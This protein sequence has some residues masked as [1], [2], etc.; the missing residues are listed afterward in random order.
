VTCPTNYG[1]SIGD[2]EVDICAPLT[3]EQRSPNTSTL[4]LVYE[5][6]DAEILCVQIDN[7]TCSLQCP[8]NY[9]PVPSVN[10]GTCAIAA[11]DNRVPVNGSCWMSGD[12]GS[13][14]S[15]CY[16]VVEVNRCYSTCPQLTSPNTTVAN[17]W[18][19]DVVPCESRVPDSRG[20]CWIESNEA[21][22][23]Y[24]NKCYSQCPELTGPVDNV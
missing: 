14:S 11:C 9:D 1:P 23:I 3:C 20:I 12:D 6:I 17:N 8:V 15:R 4:C 5:D 2:E 22:F 21:C 19:C 10:G 16:S 7:N 18:R 13:E 24:Q